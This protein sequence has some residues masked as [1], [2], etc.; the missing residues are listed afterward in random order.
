MLKLAA[1][2]LLA[3][4]AG[5]AATVPRQDPAPPARVG[6]ALPQ[7]TAGTLDIHQIVTGR[8]NAAF[9]R[10]PDGTTM[11]VDAGDGGETP[12]AEP[13]PNGAKSPGKWIA[14]YIRQM[15]GP[16]EP[17][18]DYAVVTHIHPDHMGALAE[19]SAEI[20]LRRLVD[21][22]WPD[23]GYMPP[24]DDQLF[25][26]YRAL[27][28][29]LGAGKMMRAEAG[30]AS[31]IAAVRERSAP[32][33]FSVRIVAVNDRVWT[34]RGGETKV[35][36]PALASITV[37]EDRPTENMCSV[38]MRISYGAF[39]FFTGGDMPG[40]PVPG[41]PGWHD[42][43]T[44]VARAIGPT[45]V[46]VV[47]HHG[48]I[49]EET[50]FWLATLR[51]R[52]MVVP[53]WQA[54]HPSPDVLKRMLSKRVYPQPRDIF[55]T[56]FRDATK[57]TIGA[58]ATQVASDHGHVVVRVEPGGSRYWVIVL[59]DTTEERRVRSVHGPYASE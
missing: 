49:E 3:L 24:P 44:D 38:A 52:V 30:S 28:A 29:S 17:A 43:E 40:Y 59:D 58:R 8:G 11:L 31:Q 46:H 10:F 2:L 1:A 4:V 45:D 55:I 51:S 54:T 6:E 50:L 27:T 18:L 5:G 39:D 41:A 26:G 15:T 32:A 7:W 57:A 36:F 16:S 35:R 34:G 21:R 25:K 37:P 53:A 48:S 23:Y 42:L 47:N 20:P 12:N 9:A 19:L 56:V 14:S 22:G 33:S 13:R